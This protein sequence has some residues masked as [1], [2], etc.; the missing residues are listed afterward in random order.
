MSPL[1][2]LKI[3]KKNPG[4]NGVLL[5]DAKIN[6]VYSSELIMNIEYTWI[7][8]QGKKCHQ[9]GLLTLTSFIGQF[10]HLVGRNGMDGGI[11]ILASCKHIRVHENLIM[12]PFHNIWM[13]FK[14]RE[15]GDIRLFIKLV[16]KVNIRW[17]TNF[18][19]QRISCKTRMTTSI[20]A[21][22]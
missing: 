10:V 14:T 1:F 8:W 2:N 18:G 17:L 15:G 22:L 12:Y 4:I 13:D 19:D 6:G 3:C 21:K 11:V 9:F 20:K 16:P 5:F 7:Y